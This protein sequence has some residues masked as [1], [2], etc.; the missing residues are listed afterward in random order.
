[1]VRKSSP[2]V[3]IGLCSAMVIAYLGAQLSGTGHIPSYLDATLDAR[4]ALVRSGARDTALIADAGEAWRVFTCVFAH[5]GWLHLLFN[6]GFLFP[7]LVAAE[8]HFGARRTIAATVILTAMSSMF[9]L[10]W[11]P[12]VSAGAS[13]LVFGWI[14]VLAVYALRQ[15]S[16]ASGRLQQ[17]IGVALF[18]F[19]G[20]I[21]AL[22]IGNPQLD[23]ASHAG[24]LI[25][26]L[27][28]GALLPTRPNHRESTVSPT[29]PLQHPTFWA[30]TAM[31]CAV[32]TLFTARALAG[33]RSQP[34]T[35]QVVDAVAVDIP[36]TYRPALDDLGR[37]VY[38]GHS[39]LVRLTVDTIPVY[40]HAS[41]DAPHDWAVRARL[42]PLVEASILSPRTSPTAPPTLEDPCESHAFSRAGNPVNL[43]VC[44]VSVASRKVVITLE[45]PAEWTARY[46]PMLLGVLRSIRPLPRN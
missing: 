8:R 34:T 9:S 16:A 24:G 11:T 36:P 46:R 3:A 20:L 29:R 33:A 35:L 27:V 32:L 28:L 15:G 7:A 22:S 30:L 1:M 12:E 25:S 4:L 6:V 41:T 38:R 2:W 40:R 17:T 19:L 31:V 23:H 43:E 10:A 18:P 44:A 45:T 37:V 13:G 26:G 39:N 21:L 14:S 42:T 5:T